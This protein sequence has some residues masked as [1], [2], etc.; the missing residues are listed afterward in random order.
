M[1]SPQ[2][3]PEL[4]P[5]QDEPRQLPSGAPGKNAFLRLGFERR[6]A[7]TALIDLQRRAPLLVQQ[8]LYYD[9]EM[10]DLPCVMMI[11][12]SGGILQGDRQAIEIDLAPHTRAHVTTQAATKVQQ[13]DANYAS[14]RQQI[15]LGD[16]AYLEY[17]PD[18]IIPFRN[19]RFITRTRISL[20][21]SAA[22]L[23]SEIMMPGRKYYRDGELFVYD[24]FSSTIRAERPDRTPLFTEKFVI[25]PH[26]R[27][28]RACGVM[29]GFDV[30]ANV[31]LL[32]P[33]A[34][35]DRIFEQTPAEMLDDVPLAAGACRLPNE[36]GLVYKVL[37]MEREPVQAKVR[38]FWSVVRRQIVGAGVPQEFAWR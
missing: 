2:L 8:A 13:M 20:P 12:T 30:F 4:S 6:G 1:T 24:L 21:A 15:V 33:K 17:L 29:G 16:C 25:E 36:A 23:Y 3:A 19:S 35:A 31:V 7:R 34:H 10:P 18:P 9:E 11:T 28:V 26:R 38:E 22:V 5:Y 32:A 37:G 14:Q 27:G